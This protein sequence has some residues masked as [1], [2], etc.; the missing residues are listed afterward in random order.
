MS[1]NTKISVSSFQNLDGSN[2]STAGL[3]AGLKIGK[4]S[5]GA[6]TGIGTNYTSGSTGAVI[7]FKGSL[8]YGNS[9][10]SG[11]F[12]IRNNL[13]ANS[14]TVQFRVQPAT[15]NI[16]ISKNVE[17]YIT[18]YGAAKVNYSNGQT[19]VSFGGYTG[20][21]VKNIGKNNRGEFFTEAQL[22]DFT[23][24]D[25]STVGLNAGFSIKI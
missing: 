9:P 22:Y 4:G 14:Q 10:V 8:P 6:Y 25:K 7:D 15:V 19:N 13:N 17:G 3:D 18:P 24:V 21:K 12:R 5:L 11:G 20:I 2:F 1:I 16:P 23:K